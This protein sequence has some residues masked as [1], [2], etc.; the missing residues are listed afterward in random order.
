M[1]SGKCIWGLTIY[2]NKLFLGRS[3]EKELEIYDTTTFNLER[4]LPMPELHCINDLT[5]CPECDVVYVV[6]MCNRSIHVIDMNGTRFHWSVTD[7]PHGISVNSQLNVIV[8]FHETS[9]LREFTSS[10][11]LVREINLQSDIKYPHHAVQLD[12]DRYAVVHGHYEDAGLHRVCIVNRNGQII[13]C[14]GGRRGSGDGRLHTPTRI[15]TFGRSLIVSDMNND[16]LLVF[17]STSLTLLN[18]VNSI[19]AVRM[20]LSEDGSRLY[21][22]QNTWNNGSCISGEIKVTD[23]T[24]E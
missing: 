16:R 11:Q 22:A 18:T 24:W 17:S 1:A 9:K 23:M 21:W 7:S 4:R 5:T 20:S 13:R 19:G 12:D 15:V 14:Y 6:D 10:G 8:T 2:Q 3:Y